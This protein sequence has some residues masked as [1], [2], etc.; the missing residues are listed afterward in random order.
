VPKPP[1][2]RRR[3]EHL[4]LDG[5]VQCRNRLITDD[6]RRLQGQRPRNRDTLPLPAREL[7]GI[8]RPIAGIQSH[9]L[10]QAFDERVF[11]FRGNQAVVNGGLAQELVDAQAWIERTVRV[12]EHHLDI[13]MHIGE[14]RFPRDLVHHDLAA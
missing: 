4:R 5:D 3:V 13:A 1:H 6:E 2:H 12:L 8:P 11:V 10:Q 7:V 14:I 9:L